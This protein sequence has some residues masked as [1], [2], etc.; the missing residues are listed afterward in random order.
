MADIVLGVGTSHTPQISVPW[1][2]WPNLGR[3]Q[4]PSVLFR[5]FY[6]KDPEIGPMLEERGL[7]KAGG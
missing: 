1:A 5:E 2:E 3:T 7:S 6:G 4:E